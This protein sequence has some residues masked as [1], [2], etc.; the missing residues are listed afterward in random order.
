MSMSRFVAAVLFSLTTFTCTLEREAAALALMLSLLVTALPKIFARTPDWEVFS[1]PKL[2]LADCA[3]LEVVVVVD[4]FSEVSRVSMLKVRAVSMKPLFGTMRASPIRNRACNSSNERR[5]ARSSIALVNLWRLAR[6]TVGL[7]PVVTMALVISSGCWSASISTR[8]P[9]NE[10]V[11]APTCVGVGGE[12]GTDDFVEILERGRV[13]I[14]DVVGDEL[15][16]AAGKRFDHAH[17]RIDL[18]ARGVDE[19]AED[20]AHERG[21][22]IDEIHQRGLSLL[23]Q[24]IHGLLG[25]CR[26]HKRSLLSSIVKES[27]ETFHG[28][29]ERVSPT[30]VWSRPSITRIR[31]QLAS[32]G[33]SPDPPPRTSAATRESRAARGES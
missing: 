15:G 11:S 32:S 8:T 20:V 21:G 16:R 30:A 22:E 31:V 1:F 14:A 3:L 29:M 2:K 9:L 6:A 33:E 19:R 4:E 12:G 17:V 27:A 28:R 7:V 18:L 23:L 13:E 26:C 10:S 5:P 24:K 25:R